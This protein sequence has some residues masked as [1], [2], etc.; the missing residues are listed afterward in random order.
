[1]QRLCPL[2]KALPP[3]STVLL[4][5][6]SPEEKT[7]L[8]AEVKNHAGLDDTASRKRKKECETHPNSAC[9]HHDVTIPVGTLRHNNIQNT[10]PQ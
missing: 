10:I 8:Q 5:A 2:K 1:M 6:A 9:F 3:Y 7:V 4:T